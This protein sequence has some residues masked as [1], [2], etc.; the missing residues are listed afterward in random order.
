MNKQLL[1]ER[2]KQVLIFIQKNT[3]KWGDSPT[4]QEISQHFGYKAVS[5][6]HELV[7]RLSEKGYVSREPNVRRGI[8]IIGERC[9]SCGRKF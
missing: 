3:D 9:E 8:R 7:D 1:T 5:T 4:L 2:Q 6:A